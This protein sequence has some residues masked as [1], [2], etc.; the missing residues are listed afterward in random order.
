MRLHAY[1]L[2]SGQCEEAFKFY[3]QCLD[4]KIVN[5][6]RFSETPMANQVPAEWRSKVVH[7]SLTAGDDTLMGS[8]PPPDRYQK[9]AGFSVTIAVSK[10]ADA[11]RIFDPLLSPP[12]ASSHWSNFPTGTWPEPMNIRCSKRCANPVRP[13]FSRADPT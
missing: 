9:P 8:D 2:F 6:A 12:A 5:I 13:G 7:A 11:E 10:T 3:A 1:L 4:G